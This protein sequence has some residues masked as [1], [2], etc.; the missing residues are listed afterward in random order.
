MKHGKYL[1]CVYVY[2]CSS[3]GMSPTFTKLHAIRSEKIS[4]HSERLVSAYNNI[5]QFVLRIR[6][7][8]KLTYLSFSHDGT[9]L[10]GVEGG[11]RAG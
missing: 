8:Y 4:S 11:F 5:L 2:V 1:I 3:E 6:E 10:N 9:Q 7:T